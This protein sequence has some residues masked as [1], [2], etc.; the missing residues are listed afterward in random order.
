MTSTV[1][2]ELKSFTICAF[3]GVT[4]G[5]LYSFL[6]F[7][8]LFVNCKNSYKNSAKIQGYKDKNF[9]QT[10]LDILKYGLFFF[11]SAIYLKFICFKFNLPNM[12]LYMAVGWFLGAYVYLKS[13]NKAFA[14]FSNVVYN[15]VSN[16]GG[17]TDEVSFL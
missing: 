1:F 14:I 8:F 9:I 7:V 16:I 10:V 6:N 12:R 4:S 3:A 11:I 2:S 17:S 15:K 13:F 5:V